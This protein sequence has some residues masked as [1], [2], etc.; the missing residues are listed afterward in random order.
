MQRPTLVCASRKTFTAAQATVWTNLCNRMAAGVYVLGM[1]RSGTSAATRLISFLGLETPRGD[2]LVPPSR[3]NPQG[4]WESQSLVD[5]NIG[6]LETV[7]SDFSCPALLEPGWENDD[8]LVDLRREAPAV[9]RDAYPRSPWVWKD[10]RTC[11]TFAFWHAVLQVDPAVVLVNR[12]PLEIVASSARTRG[13]ERRIYMLAMWERYLRQALRQLEGLPVLVVDYADVLSAP[14]E[15]CERTQRFLSEAGVAVQR[16][17]E[18]D[19]LG[20]VDSGLRHSEFSRADFLGAADFSEEQREL[21]IALE[22]LDGEHGSFVS[23]TLSAETPTTDV[24]LA[25]RRRARQTER[26]LTRLLELER[27]RR[28]RNSR[29]GAPAARVYAGVRRRFGRDGEPG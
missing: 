8:R 5:F 18:T 26:E 14:L 4:Y 7:G 3:K 21:F 9:F 29:V 11:L 15:F 24:L 25:E 6:I 22:T 12:N 10:P 19:V 1:H 2:D 13:E 27:G 16:P 17:S 20:F 28:L 23:P